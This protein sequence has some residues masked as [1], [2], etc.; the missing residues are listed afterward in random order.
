MKK[1]MKEEIQ[2]GDGKDYEWVLSQPLLFPTKLEHQGSQNGL[3]RNW[4]V[5]ITLSVAEL[6]RSATIFVQM[7]FKNGSLDLAAAPQTYSFNN[8]I[9]RKAPG[10][11][12]ALLRGGCSV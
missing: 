4:W 7:D 8:V 12:F 9:S 5:S 6:G 10:N 1:K 3:R 11:P 2:D